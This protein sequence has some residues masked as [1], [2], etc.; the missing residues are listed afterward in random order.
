[1]FWPLAPNAR[2]QRLQVRVFQIP[3]WLKS[4]F[5]NH[6]VNGLRV[7]RVIIRQA[8]DT[9]GEKGRYKMRMRS[10][11]LA[12]LICSTG[13]NAAN[14]ISTPTSKAIEARLVLDPVVKGWLGSGV[15]GLNNQGYLVMRQLHRAPQAQHT[16]VRFLL[17]KDQRERN[18]WM[19]IQR[20][21]G[22]THAH[23]HLFKLTYAQLPM[24]SWF[25]DDA[26]WRTKTQ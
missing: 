21:R 26:G 10:G 9:G 19:T 11:L 7:G 2:E 25:Q 8:G 15:L 17:S 4:T 12:L 20:Q 13:L 1:M 5:M 14:Y 6:D 3:R 22:G 18:A 16:R 24:G 23:H